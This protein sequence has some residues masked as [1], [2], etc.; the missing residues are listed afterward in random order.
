M[1]LAAHPFP[2]PGRFRL[3]AKQLLIEW[4]LSHTC[5]LKGGAG[6]HQ[7]GIQEEGFQEIGIFGSTHVEGPGLVER[8][9]G[10]RVFCNT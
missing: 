4:F 8:V 3:E 7:I 10:V 5:G 6:S 9:Q 1:K 2:A